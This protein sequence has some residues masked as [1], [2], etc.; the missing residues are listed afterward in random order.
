LH[1][2]TKICINVYNILGQKVATIADG[3]YTAGR[4]EID[5]NAKNNMGVQLSSGVYFY[6]LKAGNYNKVKKMILMR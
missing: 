4:Y 5:W 3:N 1:E 2:A 6:E